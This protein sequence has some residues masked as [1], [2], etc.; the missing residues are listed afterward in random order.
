MRSNNYRGV[1]DL[2]CVIYI[3]GDFLRWKSL[4]S[5]PRIKNSGRSM[6]A[7]RNSIERVKYGCLIRG[8]VDLGG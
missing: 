5:S 7:A 4:R 8:A 3:S 6:F 2:G 1:K